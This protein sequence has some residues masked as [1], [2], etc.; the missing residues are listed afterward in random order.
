MVCVKPSKDVVY[1]V[2][3]LAER[4]CLLRFHSGRIVVNLSFFRGA[5]FHLLHDHAI[6]LDWK[7]RIQMALNISQAMN[8]L[9]C[10]KPPILHKNLNSINVLV[11]KVEYF[12]FV[13]CVLTS[14]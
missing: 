8:N 6:K 13:F 1:V 11:D 2:S 7:R 12:S 10:S 9:H 3:E 14:C 4:F 5:L